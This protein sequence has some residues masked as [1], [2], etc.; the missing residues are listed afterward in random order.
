[1]KRIEAIIR[2]TKVGDVLAA[3]EKVG[4]P[5]VMVS[6][7][8]GHGSQKGVEHQVRGKTYKVALLTKKKIDIIVKDAEAD[9]IIQSI[10]KAVSTG[11]IGDGKIFVL[12][13]KEAM[14]LR[15]GEK[16]VYAI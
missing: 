5:G 8:E 6:E 14:R 9:K 4:H 3:L 12:D 11:E 7:I 15:T 13:A 2:P 16:G 10:Q 1:M